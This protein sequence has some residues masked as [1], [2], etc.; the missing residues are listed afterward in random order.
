MGAAGGACTSRIS[1]LPRLAP[2]HD[3]HIDRSYRFGI[4]REHCHLQKLTR[5]TV[6]PFKQAPYQSISQ[7]CVTN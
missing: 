5:S 4:Q 1:N 2:P 7:P 3:P 6:E